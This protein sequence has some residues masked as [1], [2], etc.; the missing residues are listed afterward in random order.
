MLLGLALV[1][2]LP[3]AARAADAKG[4]RD[5]PIL[6]RLPGCTIRECRARDYDEA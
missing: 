6:Q 1:A 4:C 5:L 2:G 3:A